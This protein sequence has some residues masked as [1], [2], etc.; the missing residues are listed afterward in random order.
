MP[1][2]R[3]RCF[4]ALWASHEQARYHPVYC[5]AAAAK[6]D[7]DHCLQVVRE[8]PSSSEELAVDNVTPGKFGAR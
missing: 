3:Q 5:T 1:C 7:F 4:D 8:I 2:V 6:A